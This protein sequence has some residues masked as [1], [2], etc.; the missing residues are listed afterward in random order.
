MADSVQAGTV[1]G[2][3]MRLYHPGLWFGGVKA[4][5]GSAYAEGAIEGSTRVRRVSIRFDES[6]PIQLWDDLDTP[7]EDTPD[8]Q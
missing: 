2:N 3:T 6:A 5:Q 7:E 1:W 4:G 8:A